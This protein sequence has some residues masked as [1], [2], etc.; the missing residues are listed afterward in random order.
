[1][2][3]SVTARWK[4]AGRP[5]AERGSPLSPGDATGTAPMRVAHL[6]SHPVQ[7]YVPLYRELA[8]RPDIDLTVYY[9]SDG[10]AREFHDPGSDGR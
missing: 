9:Y 3:P 10:S 1:M 4:E 7:Y 6:V 8:G 2:I 5:R